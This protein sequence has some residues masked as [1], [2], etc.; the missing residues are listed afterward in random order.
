MQCTNGLTLT[1]TTPNRG[2]PAPQ[3]GSTPLQ[4]VTLNPEPSTLPDPTQRPAERP[5]PPVVKRDELE[6]NGEIH[7]QTELETGSEIPNLPELKGKDG[8]KRKAKKSTSNRLEVE[9]T[10]QPD[11][12]AEP[13]PVATPQRPE[14]LSGHRE[15]TRPEPKRL[16]APHQTKTKK[17]GFNQLKPH[18]RLPAPHRTRGEP[19]PGPAP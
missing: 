7:Q 8:K 19:P 15:M 13:A 1:P 17:S 9:P 12:T 18:K 3:G 6:S 14:R 4:P 16:P 5:H 11:L 10:T 2:E